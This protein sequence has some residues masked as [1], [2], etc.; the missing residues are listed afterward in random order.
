MSGNWV[1]LQEFCRCKSAST[2]KFR[3]FYTGEGLRVYKVYVPEKKQSIGASGIIPQSA[4]N[5]I[6]KSF[7]EKHGNLPVSFYDELLKKLIVI[8]NFYAAIMRELRDASKINVKEE[9]ANVLK[10]FKRKSKIYRKN[11]L[12]SLQNPGGKTHET[13]EDLHHNMPKLNS[14][15]YVSV[16]RV[17]SEV[18]INKFANIFKEINKVVSVA[19]KCKQ[20]L[21][22]CAADFIETDLNLVLIKL[23]Y[24]NITRK[25]SL[26][27]AANKTF[28]LAS[29]NPR[30]MPPLYAAP[31]CRGNHCQIL[32]PQALKPPLLELLIAKYPVHSVPLQDLLDLRNCVLQHSSSIQTYHK[33]PNRAI[34]SDESPVHSSILSLPKHIQNELHVLSKQQV[35]LP[36]MRTPY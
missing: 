26:A 36:N 30:Y 11:Y 2:V 9:Y 20:H 10:H 16:V 34:S 3:V 15:N 19:Y 12:E 28:A 18:Q 8:C 29:E 6:L 24:A 31:K 1:L 5:E 7:P 27:K 35:T 4:L 23:H 17:N 14:K 25:P 32:T 21:K 33:I 22:R 13:P